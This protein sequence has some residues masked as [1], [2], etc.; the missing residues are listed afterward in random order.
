MTGPALAA[1]VLGVITLI[2][3]APGERRKDLRDELKDLW[4]RTDALERR[5]DEKDKEIAT[6]RVQLQQAEQRHRQE[7]DDQER[8]H[9]Q[10]RDTLMQQIATLQNQIAAIRSGL[11][12]P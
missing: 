11:I 5:N 3:K 6:L 2:V 10:E 8:R 7:R 4:E 12:Q 1:F 9:Q